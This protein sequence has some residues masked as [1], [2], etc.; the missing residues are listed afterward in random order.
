MPLPFSSDRAFLQAVTPGRPPGC[1]ACSLPL[2]LQLDPS[3][4]AGL[5]LLLVRCPGPA[6]RLRFS[7][8]PRETG[9]PG[10]SSWYVVY[11]PAR[12]TEAALATRPLSDLDL[13]SLRQY[14]EDLTDALAVLGRVHE[15]DLRRVRAFRL[16]RERATSRAV[17]V[18]RA[19]VARVASRAPSPEDSPSVQARLLRSSASLLQA[20]LALRLARGKIGR[21][22]HDAWAAMVGSSPPSPDRLRFVAAKLGLEN[23]LNVGL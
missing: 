18:A 15:E 9:L 5:P 17:V 23:V 1:P 2:P 20:K 21:E 19:E 12:E 16:A 8:V 6:C 3:G 11:R 4:G 14:E 22:E 10:A 13:V 7:L